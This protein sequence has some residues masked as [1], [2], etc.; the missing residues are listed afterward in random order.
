LDEELKN[1]GTRAKAVKIDSDLIT[2]KQTIKKKGSAARRMRNSHRELLDDDDEFNRQATTA[3]I[4]ERNIQEGAVLKIKNFNN[5]L[6]DSDLG[7]N[8]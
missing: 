4:A 7:G 5:D 2:E 6:R 3:P 8:D 1:E